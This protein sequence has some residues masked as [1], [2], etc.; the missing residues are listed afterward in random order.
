M[1]NRSEAHCNIEKKTDHLFCETSVNVL[2]VKSHR[3][4]I[5]V[6]A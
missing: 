6:L 5:I 4:L 1:D 3:P 2:N